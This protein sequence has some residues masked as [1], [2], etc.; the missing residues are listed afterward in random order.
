MIENSVREE[1]IEGSSDRNFGLLFAAIFAGFALWPLLQGGKIHLWALLAG[2]VFLLLALV[3][4]RALSGINRGWMRF[5]LLLNRIV[6]PLAIGVVYY[7]TLVP[8]GLVMRALGK[9]PLR[10]NFDR[11]AASYWIVREPP[12]PDPKSMNDQF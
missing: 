11:E 4:P 8:M 6:S 2:A 9:N 10:L 7:L 12:G 5:G 3:W 1:R